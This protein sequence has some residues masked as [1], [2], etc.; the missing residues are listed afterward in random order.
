MWCKNNGCCHYDKENNKC[1]RIGTGND[2]KEVRRRI[3]NINRRKQ[4]GF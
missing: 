1:T 2:N 3:L 4:D